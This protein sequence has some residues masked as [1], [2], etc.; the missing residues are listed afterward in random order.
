M[1]TVVSSSIFCNSFLW[2]TTDY[3]LILFL[4]LGVFRCFPFC[5]CLF[6]FFFF[7]LF[8]FRV[9]QQR[10][11]L[12]PDIGAQEGRT[13]TCR[14]QVQQGWLR[15][16][17]VNHDKQGHCQPQDVGNHCGV[18]VR[19]G[20]RLV[21]IDLVD[22]HF[23]ILGIESQQQRQEK[24][25]NDNVSQSQ[26]TQ[27]DLSGVVH[28]IERAGEQQ[29]DRTVQVLGHR[30]HDVRPKD[31]KDVVKEEPDQQN[32]SNLVRTE[33]ESLD[34]LQAEANPEDIVEGPVLF[35]EVHRHDT[36]R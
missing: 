27:F 3:T 30:D 16:L 19:L 5:C 15:R 11:D 12:T 35:L 10:R 1:V 17:E 21:D 22:G 36:A 8:F 4:V 13:Q 9:C 31:P 20:K 24:S 34:P 14:N 2:V 26:Q 7:L 18:K 29:F 25:G 32:G 6:F 28:G 33:G 23:G